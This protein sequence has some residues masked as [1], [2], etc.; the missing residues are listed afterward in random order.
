M[1]AD[2]RKQQQ[3]RGGRSGPNSQKPAFAFVE[4]TRLVARYH[5]L[6]L[7]SRGSVFVTALVAVVAAGAELK[8]VS[9]LEPAASLQASASGALGVVSGLRRLASFAAV[10]YFVCTVPVHLNTGFRHVAHA[11]VPGLCL[12][13]QRKPKTTLLTQMYCINFQ[14]DLDRASRFAPL[15]QAQELRTLTIRPTLTRMLAMS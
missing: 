6:T 7:E 13:C 3:R 9:C 2:T 12:T 11:R 14:R 5:Q 1:P 8:R 15:Q 10:T 4:G